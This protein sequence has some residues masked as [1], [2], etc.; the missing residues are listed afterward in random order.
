MGANGMMVPFRPEGGQPRG[1]MAWHE[2]KVGVLTHWGHHCT[3]TG[4]VVAQRHQRRLV[5]VLG[6]IDELQQR[7]WLEALRQGLRHASQ[8]V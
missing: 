6:D 4:K 8:V 7:L 2:V 5:T 1:K 3:R